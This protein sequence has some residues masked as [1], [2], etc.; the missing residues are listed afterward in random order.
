[1]SLVINDV[2]KMEWQSEGW[3]QTSAKRGKS[4][5]IFAS[6]KYQS[7]THGEV[8]VFFAP[9]TAFLMVDGD[10]TPWSA[11]SLIPIIKKEYTSSFPFDYE[12]YTAIIDSG[13]EECSVSV[14]EKYGLV[15]AK[16]DIEARMRD[17]MPYSEESIIN[18]G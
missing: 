7:T 2:V 8:S 13:E 11:E 12:E 6:Q 16:E 5:F 4:I 17:I 18:L 9:T 1:M 14:L 15:D 3:L 10:G